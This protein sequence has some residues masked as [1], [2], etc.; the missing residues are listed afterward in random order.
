M[1]AHEASVNPAFYFFYFRNIQGGLLENYNNSCQ[2]LQ[3]IELAVQ[4]MN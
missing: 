3:T 4:K 2:I 1:Q